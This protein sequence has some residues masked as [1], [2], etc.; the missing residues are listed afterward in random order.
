MQKK[1]VA[2]K[3]VGLQ[4][5][6]VLHLKFKL[7]QQQNKAIFINKNHKNSFKNLK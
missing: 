2:C 6:K 5:S 1:I 4:A 7:L 3:H